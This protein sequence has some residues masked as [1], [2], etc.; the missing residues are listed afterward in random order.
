LELTVSFFIELDHLLSVVAVGRV[1]GVE[2]A[3]VRSQLLDGAG[4][5]RVARGDQHSE[6]VLDQPEADLQTQ[7]IV[8][9]KLIN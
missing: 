1:E 2:V 5:E 4:S 7:A 9:F 8:R 3:H 6:V